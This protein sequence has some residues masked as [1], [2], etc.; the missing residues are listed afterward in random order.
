MKP[1]PAD[2]PPL[3]TATPNDRPVALLLRH[4]ER[5]PIPLHEHGAD[6]SLTEHGR[7]TGGP[8]ATRPSSSTSPT[9]SPGLAPHEAAYRLAQHIARALVGSPAGVHVFVTHDAILYP[10]VARLL[11]DAGPRWPDFLESAALYGPA[12][13]PTFAY[14]R[15]LRSFLRESQGP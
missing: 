2:L 10:T 12:T 1:W 13:G 4:A 14:R 15:G 9:P 7:L 3:P 11:P 8:K 5:P 6:L